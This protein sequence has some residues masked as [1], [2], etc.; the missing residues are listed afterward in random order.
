[1]QI[2]NRGILKISGER[3]IDSWKRSKFY[4]EVEVPKNC[5][6]NGIQA[7]FANG[8]LQVIMPKATT[9]PPEQ[10]KTPEVD[11]SG[12]D[13]KT[14]SEA[15]QDQV[16]KPAPAEN[17]ETAS[18]SKEKM[19]P[20]PNVASPDNKKFAKDVTKPKQSVSRMKSCAKASLNVAVMVAVLVALSAYVYYMYRSTLV[21]E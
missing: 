2:N 15:I 8:Y 13:Q 6:V 3:P 5:N 20:S 7:K 17:K 9:A 16:E 12:V 4:K 11:G 21:E 10:T 14:K 19:L 1:V 18:S